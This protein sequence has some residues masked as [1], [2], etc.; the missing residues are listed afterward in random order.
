[1]NS[2][3]RWALLW[4]WTPETHHLDVEEEFALKGKES[5]T[6]KRQMPKDMVCVLDPTMTES[7]PLGIYSSFLCLDHKA[8][9]FCHLQLEETPSAKEIQGPAHNHSAFWCQSHVPC[10]TLPLPYSS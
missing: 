3:E 4:D 7:H 6:E 10:G 9:S 2:G 1:M 5:K 8:V